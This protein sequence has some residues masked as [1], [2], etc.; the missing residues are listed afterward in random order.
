MTSA[1]FRA[2]Q[3]L[4]SLI[5]VYEGVDWP[6]VGD[7]KHNRGDSP[8]WQLYGGDVA[9]V[10][11]MF[12]KIGGKILRE[13]KLRLPL[14]SR[15]ELET[16][17]AYARLAGVTLCG[18]S[19]TSPGGVRTSVGA[20]ADG[21]TKL[22]AAQRRWWW[23][24]QL[25][26]AGARFVQGVDHGGVVEVSQEATGVR[27]RVTAAAAQTP[28]PPPVSLS[29]AA[30]QRLVAL[31]DACEAWTVN[32]GAGLPSWD[33]AVS[34]GVRVRPEAG[35]LSGFIRLLISSVSGLDVEVLPTDVPL[36][37]P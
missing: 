13:G 1:V 34:I 17:A 32:T 25:T 10:Q 36:M 26:A 35:G 22:D 37:V 20:G 28:S 29:G 12:V 24:T 30:R 8:Y 4:L 3:G 2:G 9:P 15:T 6:G 16:D 14:L 31:Q 21:L 33:V 18:A 23:D 7:Q 19:S 27:G 5:D 11:S